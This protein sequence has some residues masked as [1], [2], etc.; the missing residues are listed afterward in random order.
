[1]DLQSESLT[2]QKLLENEGVG[3]V[4]WDKNKRL[5]QLN[6]KAKNITDS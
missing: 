3:V 2:C 4:L 1:M 6:K 5:L